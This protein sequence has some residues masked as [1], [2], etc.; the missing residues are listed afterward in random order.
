MIGGVATY[1]AALRQGH[2]DRERPHRWSGGLA[3]TARA[4]ASTWF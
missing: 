2:L 3:S 4:R 1:L